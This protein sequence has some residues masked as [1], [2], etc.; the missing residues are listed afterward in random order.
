MIILCEFRFCLP[1]FLNVCDFRGWRGWATDVF[2]LFTGVGGGGG[3]GGRGV[4]VA[5]SKHWPKK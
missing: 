1:Y 4:E 2:K 3:G 5:F